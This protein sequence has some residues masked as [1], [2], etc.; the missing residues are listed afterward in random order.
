M[1]VTHSRIARWALVGIAGLTV[2]AV[3]ASPAMAANKTYTAKQVARHSSPTD[4]WTSINGSVYNLTGWI[5]KHP[6]GSRPILATCGRDGSAL[7]NGQHSGQSAPEAILR[8]YNIGT[9][10]K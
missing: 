1:V 4:C 3:S 2:A 10:K 9:L 8:S 6:G 5:A 7:F